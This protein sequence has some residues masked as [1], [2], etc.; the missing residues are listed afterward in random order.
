LSLLIASVYP[1]SPGSTRETADGTKPQLNPELQM[2]NAD[3]VVAMLVNQVIYLNSSNDILFGTR[4]FL[5]NVDCRCN[6]LPAGANVAYASQTI[7]PFVCVEQVIFRNPVTGQ[8]TPWGSHSNL[9]NMSVVEPPFLSLSHDI[10]LNARRK[11]T[12]SLIGMASNL[13]TFSTVWET[14]GGSS[15]LAQD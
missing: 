9:M 4:R 8:S 13:A 7:S 11:E 5:G 15:L 6:N 10:G 2:S 1:H 14:A 3:V 12:V